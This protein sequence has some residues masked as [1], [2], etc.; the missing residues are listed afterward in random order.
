M[1][2]NAELGPR[3]ACR[4]AVL[5]TGDGLG[6][7]AERGRI[8][9]ID[10]GGLPIDRFSKRASADWMRFLGSDL[11][12][13]GN[14]LAALQSRRRGPGISGRLSNGNLEGSPG[15]DRLAR[16]QTAAPPEGNPIYSAKTPKLIAF[17]R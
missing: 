8:L 11:A 9:L 15:G 10:A 16:S 2:G 5:P 6:T 3:P 13:P 12:N 17:S 1:A 14:A 4:P 7:W